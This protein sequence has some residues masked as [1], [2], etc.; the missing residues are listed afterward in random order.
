MCPAAPAGFASHPLGT[1]PPCLRHVH[2][3]Y[4][5]QKGV[6]IAQVSE[7]L[8]HSSQA[9][10]YSVY[11]HLIPGQDDAAKAANDLLIT[12]RVH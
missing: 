3:P 7:R 6:P 11:S 8:G 12:S 9:F 1:H 10:T 2:A 4:L 5:L